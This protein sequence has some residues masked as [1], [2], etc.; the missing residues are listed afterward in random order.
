MRS[1]KANSTILPA[2]ISGLCA[3]I[4]AYLMIGLITNSKQANISEN[5]MS[6]GI[7][8]CTSES[9]SDVNKKLAKGYVLAA[10]PV[11][12]LAVLKKKL[13]KGTKVNVIGVEPKNLTG[14][15]NARTILTNIEVFDVPTDSASSIRETDSSLIVLMS[16]EECERLFGFL[17]EG[18]IRVVIS[19][20]SAE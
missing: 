2:V 11:S 6:S 12:D 8:K 5:K 13:Q 20:G 4:A 18:T 16:I 15:A 9:S 3:A 19:A 7:S 1:L 14:A 10:L 17:A